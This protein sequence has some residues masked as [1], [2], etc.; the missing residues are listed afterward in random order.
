MDYEI[1]RSGRKTLALTIDKEGRLVVRAPY[2]MSRNTIEDF[3]CEKYDW[4]KKN[5]DAAAGRTEARCERLSLPPDKLPMLGEMCAV[6]HEQPYGFDGGKFHLPPGVPLAGLIPYLRRLYAGAA[7]E[8]LISRTELIAGRMNIKVA[9]VKISSAKTRW[10]S[11]SSGRVIN[12]SWKL[13]TADPKLIDYVIIHELCHTVH[14]DHSAEFW[15]TVAD[16]IPDYKQR[17]EELKNVQRLLSEY[18]LD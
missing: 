2:G 7:R 11:C 12:L 9:G 8:T 3:I 10:G 15:H 16:M 4:V 18:G 5:S 1:I 14:M 13:I 17:R 6:D